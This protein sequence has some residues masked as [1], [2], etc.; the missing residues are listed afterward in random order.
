M[1]FIDLKLPTWHCPHVSLIWAYHKTEAAR[2]SKRHISGLSLQ[3]QILK[4]A[5]WPPVTS[6]TSLYFG[7]YGLT[8]PRSLGASLCILFL[9]WN[10]PSCNFIMHYYTQSNQP[11]L[12]AATHKYCEVP[13]FLYYYKANIVEC[14]NSWFPLY[15]QKNSLSTPL[16]LV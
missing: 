10:M 6:H 4:Q 3:E 1:K 8:M 14:L 12:Q 15:E 11:C 13:K 16:P 2:L 9:F 7:T 5:M